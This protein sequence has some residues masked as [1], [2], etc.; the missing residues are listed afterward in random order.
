MADLPFELTVKK[1]S[2]K[3]ELNTLVCEKL[4]RAIPNRRHVYE[5][6]WNDK[7]VVVKI[8]SDKFS[9]KRHVKREWY[10]LNELK[11]RGLKAPRV[12]F[13]GKTGDGRHVIT[14]EKIINAITAIDVFNGLEKKTQKLALL[15]SICEELANQHKK[16]VF[17]KDLHLGNF[18]ISGENVFTLDP[19]QM[20][21]FARPV[22]KKKA[23]SRLAILACYIKDDDMESRTAILKRYTVARGWQPEKSDEIVFQKQH[24]IQNKRM[25]R[26]GLKKSLRTS[27]RHIKVKKTGYLGIFEKKFIAGRAPLDLVEKI[28]SIMDSGEIL[29]KGNTSYV[30][31]IKWNGK[32]VVVKRYNNK[33]IFHSLRHTIKRSRAY[34]VWLNGHRLTMLGIATPKPLAY[35]ESYRG[36]ILWKSYIITEYV[37]GL[38]LCDFFRDK[39]VSNEER[40]RLVSLVEKLLQKMGKY[41]ITHGDL[42]HTNILIT[43]NGPVLTDLDA[44]VVHKIYWLFQSKRHKDMAR[45]L[46]GMQENCFP[47]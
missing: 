6:S 30:S 18:L 17:Q 4:L 35:A 8:F 42:K 32:D 14:T 38:Q 46:N 45:F 47:K 11:K 21:F 3:T 31:R 27:K 41:K 19:G 26:R 24:F 10:G 36:P 34:R 15:F 44:M 16:G 33:G 25:I 13:Y 12:L 43:E 22:P 2:I 29:K 7:S 5:G 20:C 23:F 28:D 1:L 39:K 37:N 9:A 40:A